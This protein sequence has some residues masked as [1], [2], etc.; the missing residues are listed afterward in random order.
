V[1]HDLIGEKTMTNSLQKAKGIMRRRAH[2]LFVVAAA[3]L[4]TLFITGCGPSSPSGSNGAQ[5][6]I[7]EFPW[8]SA[9]GSSF[10]QNLL[11]EFG[12]NL[13]ALLAAAA[14]ALGM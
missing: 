7:Q 6:L 11:D 9:L 13:V 8:L 2:L 10:I 14:V 3:V 4:G 12:S 1:N 5:Q